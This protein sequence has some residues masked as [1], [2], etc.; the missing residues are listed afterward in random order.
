MP[1]DFFRQPDVGDHLVLANHTGNG[2][3]NATTHIRNDNTP[4]ACGVNPPSVTIKNVNFD[5]ANYD[6]FSSS[7][8]P[9]SS[10]KSRECLKPRGV[11]GPTRGMSQLG[12]GAYLVFTWGRERS[13]RGVAETLVDLLGGES[14]VGQL[15]VV[16]RF[17]RTRGALGVQDAHGGYGFVAEIET[18]VLVD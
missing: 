13:A 12:S 10:P 18:E 11:L 5:R 14:E 15:V 16:A 9:S 8:M 4:V 17:P 7:S 1:A 3:W 2:V 6:R